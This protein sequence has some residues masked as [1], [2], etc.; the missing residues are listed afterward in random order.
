MMAGGPLRVQTAYLTDTG[1]QREENQDACIELRGPGGEQLLVVAD[2]MGGHQGGSTASRLLIEATCELFENSPGWDGE[3]LRDAI[4]AANDRIHRAANERADLAGMG[5]TAVAVLIR[6]EDSKAWVAHVGD[7]RAYRLRGGALEPLTEDHSA[8]AELLRNGA[9][10][11]AEAANHPRRNEIIR[12]VGVFPT[13]EVDLARF[14]VERGDQIL[15]CSDGLSGVLSDEEIAA[16]LLRSEPAEAVPELVAAAN[17]HGGPD[18]VTVM[19]SALSGEENEAAVRTP[20]SRSWRIRAA[21]GAAAALLAAIALLLL[22][23]ERRIE[24]PPRDGAADAGA[25]EGDIGASPLPGAEA[26]QGRQ[27]NE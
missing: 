6:G 16:V 12:S 21:A 3:L 24:S 7:S 18:N 22:L 10:T 17:E 20:A 5:T 25:A 1:R 13:V 2:G 15:L 11:A 19:V 4:V 8:V 26:G 9:I 23:C 14:E 27:S